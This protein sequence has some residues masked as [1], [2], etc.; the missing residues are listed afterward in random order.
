MSCTSSI[1]ISFFCVCALTMNLTIINATY[2]HN[3]LIR[4]RGYNHSLPKTDFLR[5]LCIF[6]RGTYVAGSSQPQHFYAA[7]CLNLRLCPSVLSVS[8]VSLSKI[9]IFATSKEGRRLRFGR[10]TNIRSTKVL[11]HASCI[12]HHASCIIGY[13]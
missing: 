5:G 4:E 1:C 6:Y 13:F 3:N 9:K 8:F 7:C 10:L 12:T 2:F 11:H